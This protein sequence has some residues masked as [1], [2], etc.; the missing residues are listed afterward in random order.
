MST[1]FTNTPNP[2]DTE[3]PMFAPIPSW[4]RGK[5]RRS[6]GGSAPSTGSAPS[7]VAAAEERSFAPADP[8][9]ER[10]IRAQ[11]A[12]VDT[13]GTEFAGTPTYATMTTRKNNAA[14]IAIAAGLVLLGGLG[15]AG[16]YATQSHT[17]GVAELTPG[18]ATTTTTTTNAPPA[19]A[20]P[21]ARQLAVQDT[22]PPMARPAPAVARPAPA[23]PKVATHTATTTTMARRAP[24]PKPVSRSVGDTSVNAAALAPATPATPAFHGLAPAPA[25]SAAAP[26][27]QV[28]TPA[29][30][31]SVNPPAETAPAPAP[32]PAQ[33]PPT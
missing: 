4:E 21:A 32:A 14:P 30:T 15:A 27:P 25:P 23:T 7:S 22:L 2:A 31:Q 26:A 13:T 33:T 8:V 9:G 16:W 19:P 24:A 6:F 1:E 28:L 11:T 10:T 12:G 18:A 20:A 29:P 17:Q 3:S 5:K